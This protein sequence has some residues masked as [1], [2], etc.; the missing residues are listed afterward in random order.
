MTKKEKFEELSFKVLELVGGKDNISSLVHCMTRLRFDLKDKSAV[1]LSEIQKV[2]G[3][4]GAQWSN[5]QL[6][7]IIGQSVGEVYKLVAAKAGLEMEKTINE[8][9]DNGKKKQNVFAGILD[10]ISGCLIPLIPVMIGAG[11]LKVVLIIAEMIGLLN[12]DMSTYTVLKF[13]ADAGFYFLPVFLGAT[14]ANKFKTNMSLGMLMGAILI[15]PTFVANVAGGTAMTIFGISIYATNYASTIFPVIMAVYI[16]S[17]VEKFFKKI[18]PDSL[19]TIFVPLGTILVMLPLT[20]CLIG[21]AGAFLGTYMAKGVMWL[22]NTT[23]FFGVA[24]LSAIY[25]ILVITGM[26][27]AL[28]PYMFQSFASFGYEPIVTIAGILS[29]I[30]Q[31]AA[32]AAVAVKCKEKK[33]K[34]AAASSA[35]TAVVGGVTEPAMFGINLR[36]KKPLYA[37]MIG[38]FVGAGFA[39]LMKVHSVAFSGSAGIFAVITKSPMIYMIISIIIGVVVTFITTLFI[40]KGEEIY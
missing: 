2:D 8:D 28:V 21:P 13:A 36:L 37:A 40:Y 5:D 27:G 38:N 32:S 25:P 11:M 4:I 10:G 20:L 16:M 14:A 12:P 19:K 35:I 23:G 29:N 3:V 31:G 17:H 15:H 24:L 9:L 7:I 18:T 34:S 26:H 39:G 1:N 22:Y 6:Q 30:N 33:T